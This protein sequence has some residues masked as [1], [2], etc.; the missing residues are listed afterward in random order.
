MIVFEF[1]RDLIDFRSILARAVI[2]RDQRN[3]PVACGVIGIEKF[4]E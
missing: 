2:L 3:M 1:K 4:Q